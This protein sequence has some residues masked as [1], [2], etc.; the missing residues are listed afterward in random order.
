MR[1]QP[2][3]GWVWTAGVLAVSTLVGCYGGRGGQLD[4]AGETESES[5]GDGD[6]DGADDQIPEGCEAT[7]AP[8][9]RL[10]HTEYAN[11]LRDLLPGATLPAISLAADP[12]VRGFSNNAGALTPSDLLTR[13]Y[14]EVA[15]SIARNLDVTSLASCSSNT[16][17]C[18]ADFVRDFG[19][20]AF[21]RPL[22]SDEVDTFVAL[23]A[24]GGSYEVGAR[25]VV[26]AMLQSPDFLY[27]PELGGENRTLTGYE[28]ASRLSYFLWA[29]M[30]D[31]ALLDAAEAGELDSLAGVQS[32]VERMLLDDKLR[33]GVLVFHRE[34]LDLERIR[35]VMKLEE[36][37]FDAAFAAS[38][39]ESAERFVW[40]R[41]FADDGSIRDLLVS[42]QIPVDAN[43]AALFG[44]DPPAQGWHTATVDGTQH[45]GI[46]TQPA[47]LAS[48]AY[49]GYPSPVLRGVFVLDRVLCTPVSPPPPGVDTVL[50]D[51]DESPEPLTNRQ[52]YENATTAK[53]NQCAACHN[54]INP[55]GYAF[56]HYDSMGRH[57]EL[58]NGM[59]VD[60]SGT[61]MGLEYDDG[62]D[63]SAQIASS[64]R[65][66]GCVVDNWI[67]YATGGN[68]ALGGGCVQDDLRQTLIDSDMSAVEL[69][70]ALA[71]HPMFSRA[72]LVSEE[73]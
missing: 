52:W 46:L 38:M 8:I 30:P 29:T 35:N 72:P 7:H 6:G 68:A 25:L 54:L 2:G 13:Q 18:H 49:A 23:F 47:V 5:G 56:E 42:T 21:R 65:F 69:V 22:R 70:A 57:R 17:S 71:L 19:R 64:D 55:V 16:A 67:T 59:P 12:R 50:P 61:V 9:R 48:H 1:M 62:V 4:A 45:A 20:R 14:Y 39:Q 3:H 15:R 26:Q 32:H 73:E 41:L 33:D 11:T 60:A 44:V 10:S 34:W 27:R 63:L 53:G 36:E 43:M 31:D 28:T 40:D 51:P 58:D 37:G 66:R 24:A